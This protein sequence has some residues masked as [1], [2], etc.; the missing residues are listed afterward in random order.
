MEIKNFI[1]VDELEVDFDSGL[2][3]LTGETGAGKSILLEALSLATG[4]RAETN[5][6][7]NSTKKA[8][9]TAIF[10]INKNKPAKQMLRENGLDEEICILRR[11][12]DNDGRSKAFCNDESVT[13]TFLKKISFSLLDIHSQH[14]SQSLLKPDS[15]RKYI[16]DSAGNSALVDELTS[17]YKSY[18]SN[19]SELNVLSKSNS[20]EQQLEL[21]ELQ[22]DERQN[23]K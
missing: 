7:K 11:I 13:L 6:V 8:T 15:Q 19:L 14:Q 22:L 23:L 21:D 9:I 12:L 3:V 2:T 20:D 5:Y 18:Q 16:D 1:I 4:K 10:E 17:I